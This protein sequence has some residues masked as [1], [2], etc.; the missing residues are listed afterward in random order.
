MFQPL[1]DLI[2]RFVLV[3]ERIADA[4]ELSAKNSYY[5]EDI[6]LKEKEVREQKKKEEEAKRKAILDE[7]ISLKIPYSPEMSTEQL[8]KRLNE[9]RE[10][11]LAKLNAPVDIPGVGTCPEPA[12]QEPAKTEEAPAKPK[13]TKSKAKK[14]AA[15]PEPEETEEAPVN[16]PATVSDEELRAFCAD[17]C[18]DKGDAALVNFFDSYV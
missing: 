11:A 3:M 1:L 17:I 5:K 15:K 14:E 4:L 6:A 7:L 16:P 12:K 18:Q 2:E 9:N 13:A 8:E 10:R